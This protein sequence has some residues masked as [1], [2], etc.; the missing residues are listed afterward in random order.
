M[1]VS[2]QNVNKNQTTPKHFRFTDIYVYKLI[3]K[4]ISNAFFLI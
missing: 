4:Q 3:I 2:E 1:A